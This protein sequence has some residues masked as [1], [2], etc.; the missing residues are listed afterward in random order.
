M[1]PSGNC[2]LSLRQ[3]GFRYR[4]H[5]GRSRARHRTVHRRGDSGGG[6]A[7]ISE[8]P[9]RYGPGPHHRLTSGRGRVAGVETRSAY[10]L[11]ENRLKAVKSRLDVFEVDLHLEERNLVFQSG[12]L[13]VDEGPALHCCRAAHVAK[14]Q[15]LKET[16]RAIKIAERSVII[17]GGIYKL[18][19]GDVITVC[20]LHD[21]VTEGF[22]ERIPERNWRFALGRRSMDTE[23][24]WFRSVPR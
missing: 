15:T 20:C 17:C 22:I 3:K 19:D 23:R 18:D 14:P 6:G 2:A 8:Q 16:L 4:A 13:D 1:M 11:T 10:D 9:D 21:D 5:A 7:G 24:P 12:S